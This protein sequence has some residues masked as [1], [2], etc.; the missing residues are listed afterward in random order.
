LTTIEE[1]FDETRAQVDSGRVP[2]CQAAVGHRGEV[3]AFEAFGAATEATRFCV[4]S[5]TKPIV[6]SMLWLL[7]G[8]GVA[9]PGDAVG[10]YV[11]ELVAGGLGEVTLE[12]LL[13][14][15]AGF[16][17]APMTEAEGGDASRRRARFATWRPE[18]PPGT[19]FEYH[20]ESAHWVLADV[21]ERLTGRDYRD[22][23]EARV[24]APLGIPRVLGLAA[25]LQLHVCE[26]A[27]VS[28]EADAEPILRF[29]DTAVRASGNPAGG[30]IMTAADLARFYQGVL[31]NP[32]G[33]W[34][35]RVLRDVT[36]NVRCTYDDPLM[37][38]SVNR[39]L[40]FVLAGS[41][42][43]HELRYAIFGRACSPGAF[44]HAGAHAQVAW[45]DPGTGISFAFVTNAIDTDMMRSGARSNR[46]ATI[47]A[48]LDL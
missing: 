1:L 15:T 14:H 9:D 16:P 13:L 47:A 18:W 43:L 23:L 21:V 2:A 38:V 7:F 17:N 45:A 46:L 42:G 29:N 6:A 32:G 48:D 26:L 31:H 37:G 35:E 25:E 24:C 28:P 30:A 19:R 40:G 4:F 10:R 20:A 11:P 5:A 33:L 44:G 12:Q 39:T 3:V 41:D 8:E 27:P 22:V 34:D 36:T